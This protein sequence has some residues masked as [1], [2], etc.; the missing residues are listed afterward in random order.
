MLQSDRRINRPSKNTVS[1]TA[2]NKPPQAKAKASATTANTSPKPEPTTESR[3]NAFVARAQQYI[4]KGEY[5]RAVKELKDALRIDPNHGVAHAVMGKAYLH[6]RQLTMAKV[7]I[8]K[9]YKAEPH[10]PIVVESK[11]ALDKLSK[12]VNKS[13]TSQPGS[14]SSKN[15]KPGNSGFFSGFFGAKKK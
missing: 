14:Q 2:T 10:N 1:T 12:A 4:S 5:D 7:H 9:A 11:K 8:S 6:K 3:V 15:D 13:K